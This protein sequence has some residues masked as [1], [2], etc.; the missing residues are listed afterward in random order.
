MS[1]AS[2]SA[3]ARFSEWLSGQMAAGGAISTTLA[4]VSVQLGF[5]DSIVLYAGAAVMFLVAQ[6]FII[7]WL[8]GVGMRSTKD[9]GFASNRQALKY[10]LFMRGLDSRLS[11]VAVYNLMASLILGWADSGK[12]VSGAMLLSFS[13]FAAA[14][15]AMRLNRN[16]PSNGQ[17]PDV[18]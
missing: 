4:L 9:L 12:L 18:R 17:E 5:S 2:P 16:W 7:R 1:D 14:T 10:G 15:A 8:F 6:I 13:T 3:F 11:A